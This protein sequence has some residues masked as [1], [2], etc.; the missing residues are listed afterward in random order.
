MQFFAKREGTTPLRPLAPPCHSTVTHPQWQYL[1]Y[2]PATDQ[3]KPL[4]LVIHNNTVMWTPVQ[5]IPPR[6]LKGDFFFSK[7]K[8]SRYKSPKSATAYQS[9]YFAKAILKFDGIIPT[10]Q[11]SNISER[12]SLYVLARGYMY[13]WLETNHCWNWSLFCHELVLKLHWDTKQWWS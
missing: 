3:W 5:V 9:R 1:G 12:N 2:A 4:A 8:K 10:L 6:K 13:T 7:K 11:N